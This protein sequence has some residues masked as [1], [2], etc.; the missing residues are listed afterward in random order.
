[1]SDTSFEP[2]ELVNSDG[3][4]F[5][6]ETPTEFVNAVYGRGFRR[7]PAPAAPAAP[8]RPAPASPPAADAKASAADRKAK[9]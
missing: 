9:Q 8:A 5:V 4:R 1:M 3:Q 2:V 7:A 6:A